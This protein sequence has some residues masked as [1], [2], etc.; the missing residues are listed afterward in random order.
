MIL[1][2]DTD[3]LIDVALDRAPWADPAVR[4]LELMESNPDRAFIAWHTVSNFYYLVRPKRGPIQTRDFLRELLGFVRVAPTRTLHLH[5]AIQL[6][7]KD[8][9][10]AMQVAAAMAAG[11]DTIVTR[12]LADYGGSPIEALSP[13]AVLDAWDG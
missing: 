3:V 2:I 12:N 9:E 5:R 10:D 4:L 1:L 7:M 8:F 6:E 13:Q 11:A